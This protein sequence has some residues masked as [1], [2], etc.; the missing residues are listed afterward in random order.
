[1]VCLHNKSDGVGSGYFCK[2]RERLCSSEQKE[3]HQASSLLK[4]GRCSLLQCTHHN[5]R[6]FRSFG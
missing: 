2:R 5:G 3:M 6:G 1:M 4:A